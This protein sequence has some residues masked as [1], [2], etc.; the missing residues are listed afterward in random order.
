MVEPRLRAAA[1]KHRSRKNQPAKSVAVD[2]VI[3]LTALQRTHREVEQDIRWCKGF[4]KFQ[5][6]DVVDEYTGMFKVFSIDDGETHMVAATSEQHA[7]HFYGVEMSDYASVEEYISDVGDVEV[8]EIAGDTVV[9]VYDIDDTGELIVQ[10]AAEWAEVES[11]CLIS[12][13]VN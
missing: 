11:P 8:L 1:K 2:L 7:L 5:N 3:K 4:L 12:T 6:R 9:P 10:T 13:T